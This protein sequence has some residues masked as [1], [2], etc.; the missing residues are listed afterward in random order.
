M[1]RLIRDGLPDP[2]YTE[3]WVRDDRIV[4]VHTGTVGDR[5]KT[6][7]KIANDSEHVERLIAES[8]AMA[9]EQGFR[10][11]REDEWFDMVLQYHFDTCESL[12]DLLAHRHVL[13]NLVSQNLGWNG[14]G[15]VTGG[16]IGNDR[17]NIYCRVICPEMAA[18]SALSEL[19]TFGFDEE[20]IA[21][22]SHGDTYEVVHPL[23]FKGEFVP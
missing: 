14:Y 19:E 23:D 3:I 22:F 4:V 12:P 10:E 18:F 6:Q 16:D 11:I 21:A 9:C 17:F 2:D 15:R 5:G 1:L 13:E 7:E 8:S 20:I